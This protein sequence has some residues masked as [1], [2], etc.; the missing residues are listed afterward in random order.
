MPGSVTA[1]KRHRLPVD[2]SDANARSLQILNNRDRHTLTVS[3]FANNF[4]RV[5]MGSMGAVRKVQSRRIHAALY[6]LL[7]HARAIARRTDGA[8]DFRFSHVAALLS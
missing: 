6:E 5:S 2:L 8:D 1:E 7:K 3:R 4:D